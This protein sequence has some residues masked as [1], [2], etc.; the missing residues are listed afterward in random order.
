M[1]IIKKREYY[2]LRYSFR[3]EGK[4]TTKDVYLGKEVPGN[5]E[6]IKQKIM[7]ERQKQMYQKFEKIR[8]NFQKEWKKSPESAKQREK[9][10]IAI[11]FTYNTEAIEGSTITLEETREIVVDKIAPNKSLRDIKETEVHF[12]VFLN[13]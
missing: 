10:E 6:E 8:T 9:E 3:N 13:M 4:V 12:K 11:A 5:I 1:N 2:Y 7:R